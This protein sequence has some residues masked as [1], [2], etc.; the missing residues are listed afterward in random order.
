MF[1]AVPCSPSSFHN[2]GG[3]LWFFQSELV[4]PTGPEHFYVPFNSICLQSLYM[5]SND[6]ES[7]FLFPIYLF[8][9]IYQIWNGQMFCR[10]FQIISRLYG[11]SKFDPKQQNLPL[12]RMT[13]G[14]GSGWGTHLVMAFQ[15]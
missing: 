7:L 2:S 1:Q 13:P 10:M 9:N 11:N 3:F 4:P 5:V 12:N 14:A 15:L 6:D 8:G